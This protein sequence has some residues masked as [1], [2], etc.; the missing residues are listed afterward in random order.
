MQRSALYRFRRKLSNA[1]FLAKF[2][3][4]NEPCRV[5]SHPDSA[6]EADFIADAWDA[7][8]FE[9]LLYL[10]RRQRT[11]ASSSAALSTKASLDWVAKKDA[12]WIQISN[13]FELSNLHRTLNLRTYSVTKI[14]ERS[15][16]CK[17]LNFGNIRKQFRQKSA[18]FQQYSG[19]FL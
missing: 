10:L 5:P 2:G 3:F 4:E 13:L 12:G 9:A 19:K 14:N 16:E 17:L 15:K 6:S 8:V 18:K 1:Y 7:R 11:C